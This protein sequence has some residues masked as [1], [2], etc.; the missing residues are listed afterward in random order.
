MNGPFFQEDDD[1]L[2]EFC[3]RLPLQVAGKGYIYIIIYKYIISPT[4]KPRKLRETTELTLAVLAVSGH[5]CALQ[6]NLRLWGRPAG[7]PDI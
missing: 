3:F 1:H 5:F 4:L 6:R 2:P 7:K